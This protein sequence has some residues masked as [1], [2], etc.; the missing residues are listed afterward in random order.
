MTIDDHKSHLTNLGK[1]LKQFK[2]KESVKN[3]G[4]PQNDRFFSEMEEKINRS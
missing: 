3:E 2:L 4:L 1:F